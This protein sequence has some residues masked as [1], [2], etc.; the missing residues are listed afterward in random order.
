M[1]WN[2]LSQKELI[3]IYFGQLHFCTPVPQAGTGSSVLWTLL[4]D[5]GAENHIW[6]EILPSECLF[7]AS[8]NHTTSVE[9][10]K[11]I[12]RRKEK[13]KPMSNSR[14]KDEPGSLQPPWRSICCFR[15]SPGH[16]RLEVPLQM[17]RPFRNVKPV[18]PRP[19][20]SQGLSGTR[21]LSPTAAP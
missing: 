8:A 7:S 5:L 12:E 9:K 19:V 4:S 13:S 6:K 14:G 15:P 18:K 3:Y 11:K 17:F 1:A 16:H 21:H 10:E 20:S 2:L